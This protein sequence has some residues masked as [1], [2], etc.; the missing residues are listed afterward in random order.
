MGT[1]RTGSMP[2]GV[3]TSGQRRRRK[4]EKTGHLATQESWAW[5]SSQQ[6]PLTQVSD[7]RDMKYQ[8]SSTLRDEV[9]TASDSEPRLWTNVH[10][11][12]SLALLHG[13]QFLS[14][15]A[16]RH[17]WFWLLFF[18]PDPAVGQ[19]FSTRGGSIYLNF[20]ISYDGY[21]GVHLR[22]APVNHL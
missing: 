6:V 16:G 20:V 18:V 2:G 13:F 15:S 4:E 3:R 11:A 10:G 17:K 1:F 19:H 21:T 22:H 12:G 7:Q 8:V 14:L 5:G 9:S